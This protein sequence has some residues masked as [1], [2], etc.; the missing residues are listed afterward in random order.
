MSA[1]VVA[2]ALRSSAR[3]AGVTGTGLIL[4][5]GDAPHAIG[6]SD[7]DAA[8]LE[9]AQIALGSGPAF[10]CMVGGKPVAV[11]DLPTGYPD[12]HPEL[13]PYTGP[14]HAVLSVPI[15]VR[16]LVSGS[17]DLYDHRPHPWSRRQIGTARGLAD[18]M[19]DMLFLLAAQ[20]APVSA[21]LPGVTP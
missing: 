9:R 11:C 8:R 3:A 19:A 14:V 2:G 15:R 21:S 1:D 12:G 13:A 16:G 6:G 18:V 10:R 4:L 17:L 5:N 7:V 20:R